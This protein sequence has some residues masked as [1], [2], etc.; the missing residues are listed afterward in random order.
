LVSSSGSGGSGIITNTRKSTIT[1][2]SMN[3]IGITSCRRDGRRK[4]DSNPG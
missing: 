4:S 2:T 1:G 3:T